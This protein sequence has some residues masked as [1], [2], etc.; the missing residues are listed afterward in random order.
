MKVSVVIPVYNTEK[1]L[2]ECIDSLLAQ[3]ETSSEFIFVNDG[4]PDNSRQIIEEYQ[5]KD[6]RIVLINQKNQGVSAARNAGIAVAHG[7]YVAFVDGDDFIKKD[8]LETLGILG[9][10]SGAEII[11]SNFIR[12]QDGHTVVAKSPFPVN[13]IFDQ[14]AIREKIYG[15]MLQYD[16]MNSVANKMYNRKLLVENNISFPVGQA[17]GEDAIFNLQA[18]SKAQK[19]IFSD[20]AG[21][22]YREVAGSATRNIIQKDYFKTALEVFT[23][24]YTKIMGS[25]IPQN[26]MERLK[27]LR[28]MDKVVSYGAIYHKPNPEIGIM[29]RYGYIAGMISNDTVRNIL[30]NHWPGLVSGQSKFGKIIL[31]CMKYRLMPLLWLAYSYSYQRNKK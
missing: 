9:D 1:Y 27:S 14:D 29:K 16:A 6:Q 24:D 21:Y 31:Y 30:K 15:Y 8:M 13:E 12:E 17:L 4:S 22:F 3:T 18:L 2:R 20:Y 5:Q 11:L 25:A 19:I 23:F 7:E 28:L 10:K 26:E